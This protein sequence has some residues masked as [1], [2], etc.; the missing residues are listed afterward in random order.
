MKNLL[1]IEDEKRIVEMRKE[2]I[3]PKIIMDLFDI[4]KHHYYNIINRNGVQRKVP[5]K[6]Y[7]QN[8]NYFSKIDNP[9]KA[10]WLGFIFADGYIREYQ[11]SIGLAS[12]D[13][14]HLFRFLIDIGSNSEIKDKVIKK[15]Y[16]GVTKEYFTSTFDI[17]SIDIYNDLLKYG[18]HTKK[19]LTLLPPENI[20]SEYYRDFI[21]G[22]FDGD[23]C[24]TNYLL[25]G[26]IHKKIKILGTYLFLEW[27]NFILS[28]NKIS[29][30]KI[31][32]QTN[33]IFRL[34]YNTK[35][36]DVIFEFLYRNASTY[37]QRKKEKFI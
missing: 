20:P 23:G 4:K 2:G 12:K 31:D 10:Y 13:R 32:K 26:K 14:E 25:S 17:Y 24:I 36:S 16:K 29:K 33:K 27:I 1:N 5:N 15:K 22:Y 28:E 35:D 11:L 6:K 9:N 21:R 18:L 19:S 34:Q 8:D 30:R 7:T 3:S 37:L